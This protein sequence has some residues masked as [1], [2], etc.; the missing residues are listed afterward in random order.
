M[1]QIPSYTYRK[2]NASKFAR[3]CF[4]Q[5]KTKGEVGRFNKSDE[6]YVINLMYIDQSKTL[7]LFPVITFTIHAS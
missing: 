1:Y 4:N 7:L 6:I 2:S 3:V 5:D